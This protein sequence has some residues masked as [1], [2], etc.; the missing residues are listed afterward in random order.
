MTDKNLEWKGRR[1]N[2]HLGNLDKTGEEL[3]IKIRD[4]YL[5]IEGG[6]VTITCSK[7]GALNR[8]D[9]RSSEQQIKIM[10][11]EV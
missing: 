7:C 2:Y 11:K 8:L 1:C 4:R 5:W 9:Q 10:K 6:S 3:S